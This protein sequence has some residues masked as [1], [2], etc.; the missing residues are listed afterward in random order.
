MVLVLILSVNS[1]PRFCLIYLLFCYWR[2][3][4][5]FPPTF[6]QCKWMLLSVVLNVLPEI[7]VHI[8]IRYFTR[9]GIR[10]LVIVRC[11]CST[12][13]ASTQRIYIMATLTY[14]H[15]KGIG[16][17]V[18]P[19]LHQHLLSSICLHLDIQV[20]WACTLTLNCPP[21]PSVRFHTF[22]VICHK[23]KNKTKS[24]KKALLQFPPPPDWNAYLFLPDLAL[25]LISQLWF[26][27]ILLAIYNYDL[28]FI[29]F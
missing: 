2:A 22:I 16:V 7:H 26:Y 18:V 29:N 17:P 4:W 27:G 3:F 5:G 15:S 6:W 14:S 12:W 9:R 8:C 10:S 13:A 24:T 11:W 19:S 20:G 23:L 1:I 28:L 21:S 25:S